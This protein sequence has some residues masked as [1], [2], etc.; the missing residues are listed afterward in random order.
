[1][2]LARWHAS[3]FAWKIGATSFVKVGTPSSAATAVPG[4]RAAAPAK[5][6]AMPRILVRIAYVLSFSLRDRRDRRGSRPTA[7]DSL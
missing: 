1:M 5:T 2:E 3:H 7:G 4:T 6:T